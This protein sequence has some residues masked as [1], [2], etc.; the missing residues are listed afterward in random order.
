LEEDI[1]NKVSKTYKW[2][3][4]E[5]IDEPIYDAGATAA[6]ALF[7]KKESESEESNSRVFFDDEDSFG[8]Q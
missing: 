2:L 6:S 8:D 4:N 3:T 5:E 1:P 7:Q